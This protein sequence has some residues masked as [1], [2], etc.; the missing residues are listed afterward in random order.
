VEARQARAEQ[1]RQEE[2]AAVQ[3]DIAAMRRVE[4]VAE[5]LAEEKRRQSAQPGG[6]NGLSADGADGE[7]AEAE[8]LGDGQK[9]G[10]G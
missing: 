1:E 7:A 3:R 10:G 6:K 9:Y 8:G 5:I 2:E 4:R